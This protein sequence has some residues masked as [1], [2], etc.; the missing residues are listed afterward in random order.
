MD[1]QIAGFAWTSAHVR[2]VAPLT[3]ELKWTFMK[4]SLTLG[5]R[6]STVCGALLGRPGRVR[7]PSIAA[8][9]GGNGSQV[10]SHSSGR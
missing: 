6:S 4:G 2:G 1:S 9:F 10:D 8:N 3:S 5:P 7:F